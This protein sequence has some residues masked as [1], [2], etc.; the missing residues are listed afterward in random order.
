MSR[1]CPDCKVKA[2]EFHVPGCDVERCPKCGGQMISCE[3]IYEFCGYDR[4]T[5]EEEHPDIW[6]DGPTDEMYAKWDAEFDDKR[7]RWRAE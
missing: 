1:D 2:G 4:S 7:I 6:E 5:L 3:C